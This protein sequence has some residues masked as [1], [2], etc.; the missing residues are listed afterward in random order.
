MGWF[1]FHVL[2]GTPLCETLSWQEMHFTVATYDLRRVICRG[3][4]WIVLMCI[5]VTPSVI[6]L[7][8]TQKQIV[9][10][11]LGSFAWDSVWLGELLKKKAFPAFLSSVRCLKYKQPT[12]CYH[13]R[14]KCLRISKGKIGRWGHAGIKFCPERPKL[15]KNCTLGIW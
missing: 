2:C 11:D 5:W 3:D 9:Y 13:T 14:K 8:R 10:C 4:H 7:G 1:V 15:L 6:S 12:G